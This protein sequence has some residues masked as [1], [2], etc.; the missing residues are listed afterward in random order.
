LNLLSQFL[1]TYNEI[2]LSWSVL[3]SS[4]WISL[5][6]CPLRKKYFI[7]TLC[8]IQSIQIFITCLDISVK[9]RSKR[10]SAPDPMDRFFR[11]THMIDSEI[12]LVSRMLF[13]YW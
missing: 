6:P 12:D 1:T 3:T 11:W 8:S 5:L 9:C 10:F 13:G 2:A 7:I 4:L